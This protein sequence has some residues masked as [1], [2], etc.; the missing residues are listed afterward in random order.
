MDRTH[1]RWMERCL[2]LARLGSATAAPNP[3]VGA[4]LVQGDRML[5]EGWHERAGG[6]HAEVNCLRAYEHHPIP[7][8]ATLYVNLEPCS[9][10]GRTPPCTDLI[11][12]LGVK[13]V[14]V[15]HTDP[16]P[17]VSGGGVSR[18]RAAGVN[19]TVGVEEAHARWVNRRFLTSEEHQRPY[20]VLKWAQSADGLLDRHPRRD[21]AVVRISS[22]ATDVLVHRWRCEEQAILVGSRTVLHDDP[23]L[24]VRHVSGRSPLRI[25]IDRQGRTPVASKVFD[26]SVPT[27]L[28]TSVVRVEVTAEQHL[29]APSADPLEQLLEEL[30]RRSIRSLL[31]EGGGELLGHFIDRGLWDEARVIHS[32]TLLDSGTPAP[33]LSQEPA[34]VV[35]HDTDIVHYHV[36]QGT[37][38]PTW[39]W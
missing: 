23:R 9:H 25:V 34:R 11:L 20:I 31:V 19:V 7:E 28:L 12:R 2:Q 27:L 22:P 32:P 16:F 8:D 13:Q 4:V 37:I 5:A 33:R 17:A 21:R 39:P 24:D 38:H 30:H 35:P 36:R 26:G 3:L 6:P 14:V 1:T 29:L 10:H 18:L 15:A